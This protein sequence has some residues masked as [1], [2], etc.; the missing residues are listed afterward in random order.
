MQPDRD[1]ASRQSRAA[2][3]RFSEAKYRRQR[4]LALDGGPA[5]AVQRWGR[6]LRQLPWWV[7]LL[8]AGLPIAADF[9]GHGPPALR[10]EA[11]TFALAVALSLLLFYPL[12]RRLRSAALGRLAL[13]GSGMLL[14][15][16]LLYVGAL[17][18]LT[19]GVWGG[20]ERVMMGL[21]CLP[22]IQSRYG[23]QCPLLGA[24][25]LRAMDYDASRLWTDESIALTQL[26]LA[27][28]WMVWG[29]GLA[30]ALAAGSA[31]RIRRQQKR[32]A[33]APWAE[34][35]LV[36]ERWPGQ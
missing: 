20:G 12:L 16:G 10:D 14:A 26:L 3:H 17:Y 9:T 13:V 33:P 19:V 23:S 11:L 24:P 18:L 5:D 29:V 34:S 36:E 35:V 25:L 27:G 15:G 28:L 6:E 22:E 7:P 21:R 30:L 31:W 32:A 8:V 2:S 1:E 4:N